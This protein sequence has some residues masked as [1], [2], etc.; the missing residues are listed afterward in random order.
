MQGAWRFDETILQS[1]SNHLFHL[2]T[3]HIP[4]VEKKIFDHGN[5]ELDIPK[6]REK[7]EL[8]RKGSRSRCPGPTAERPARPGPDFMPRA[9][10]THALE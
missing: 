4:T 2:G 3:F 8:V 10:G 6:N 5:E 9:L 1:L 7:S